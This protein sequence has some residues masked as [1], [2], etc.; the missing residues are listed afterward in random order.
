MANCG[1]NTGNSMYKTISIGEKERW[2]NAMTIMKKL[3]ESNLGLED[4]QAAAIV[5][6]MYAESRWNPTS[7][8][9]SDAGQGQSGGLCQWHDGVNGNGRFTNLLN[10]AKSMNKTWQ[11][12]EV[13]LSYLVSE[14]NGTG[15]HSENAALIALKKTSNIEDATVSFCTKFERPK[16][17][18]A[19]GRERITYS[20]QVLEKWNA[21]NN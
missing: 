1:S 15:Q 20:K 11:N 13:Q 14:L 3:L 9:A 7:Y 4:F 5:G 10:S 19:R 2:N 21:Q 12:I 18:Q 17:A 6:N 16:N 8:V